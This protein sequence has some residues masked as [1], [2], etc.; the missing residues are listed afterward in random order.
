MRHL[1]VVELLET[2]LQAREQHEET[3]LGHV[4]RLL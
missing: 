2:L 4:T 1:E 3:A